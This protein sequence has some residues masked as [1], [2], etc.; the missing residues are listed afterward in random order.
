MYVNMDDRFVVTVGRQLGCG[1]KRIGEE[2]AA[3]F[4]ISCYD[5][6]LILLASRESGICRE[7][8]E[9]ADEK[10]RFSIAGGL[11]GLRSSY[12]DDGYAGN[13]LCNEYLFKIQSGVIRDLAE[14][15][16][17]IFVGRCADYILRDHPRCINIFICADMKDRIQRVGSEQRI[18]SGKAGELIER[19]DKKRAGYY[20]YY[21]NK[22]WGMAA[23]YHLCVN[24]SNL[25]VE[26]AVGLVMTFVE[27]KLNRSSR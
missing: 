27:E 25:S 15:Q 6:E 2:L 12:A 4:G 8:F 14:K 9:Q 5:R 17:C 10:V 11:L 21:T 13:Y 18:G 26:A 16:S 22:M 19:S 20:N 3:R 1:G 23:S 24:T 7:L